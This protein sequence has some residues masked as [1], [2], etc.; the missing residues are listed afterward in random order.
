MSEFLNKKFPNFAKVLAFSARKRS[1]NIHLP[2]KSILKAKSD[3]RCFFRHIDKLSQNNRFLMYLSPA[4]I[5]YPPF[6][7]SMLKFSQKITLRLFAL[8]DFSVI[9]CSYPLIYFAGRNSGGFGEKRLFTAEKA[10]LS[11]RKSGISRWKLRIS[12]R[13]WKSL[14][15]NRKFLAGIGNFHLEIENLSQELTKSIWKSGIF[16]RN[17]EFPDGNRT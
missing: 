12:R 16:R 6:A 3:F 17:R 2:A 8:S 1:H 9:L 7:F 14:S 5:P 10:A 11:V 4:G 13:N 15:G